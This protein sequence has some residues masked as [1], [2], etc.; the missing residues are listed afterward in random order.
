MDKKV[1]KGWWGRRS[2]KVKLGIISI[3]LIA[4]FLI[5]G[6]SLIFSGISSSYTF[7]TPNNWKINTVSNNTTL[8]Q[9]NGSGEVNISIIS[10][11]SSNSNNESLTDYMN[12]FVNMYSTAHTSNQINSKSAP[13]PNYHL[14][15]N[16]TL[17][18]NGLTGFD[19]IF[20][21]SENGLITDPPI[22]VEVA[23]LKKGNNY[24]EV[25]LDYSPN[26]TTPYA[27]NDFMTIVNSL[28]IN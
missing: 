3:S 21:T 27:H 11:N 23:V 22:Y 6:I 2:L 5:V 14:L 17:N 10:I 28:K 16:N 13:Y 4:L 12:N 9:T 1:K 8:V 15:S 25:Q 19:M 26:A 7:N 18:I 24:C 20:Q